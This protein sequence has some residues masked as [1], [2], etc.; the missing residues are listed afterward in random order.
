MEHEEQQQRACRWWSVAGDDELSDV[1][2][3]LSKALAAI[4][5]REQPAVEHE[6]RRRNSARICYYGGSRCDIRDTLQLSG[7]V[8]CLTR[9]CSTYLGVEPQ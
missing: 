6:Y 5:Q 8:P 7:N 4:E 2:R 1:K 3:R 9:L